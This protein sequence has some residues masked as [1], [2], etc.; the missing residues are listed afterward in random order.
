MGGSRG[1]AEGFDWGLPVALKS[2]RSRE[3]HPLH[4]CFSMYRLARFVNAPS[5]AIVWTVRTSIG[6]VLFTRS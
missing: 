5:E 4:D 2:Q 1:T 3:D 6:N